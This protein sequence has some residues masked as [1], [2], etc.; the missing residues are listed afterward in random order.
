MEE[1]RRLADSSIFM[2]LEEEEKDC[3]QPHPG[4]D[5]LLEAAVGGRR[6]GDSSFRKEK[7][8]RQ[9]HPEGKKGWQTAAFGGRRMTDS[10]L[11]R[12]RGVRQQHP[13]GK[14]WLTA[15]FGVR[16]MGDSSIRR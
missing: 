4:K 8:Y 12:K 5:G 15:A 14:E 2:H 1:Q 10:S 6:L 9:Q 11:W 16:R 7:D 3:S 13:E